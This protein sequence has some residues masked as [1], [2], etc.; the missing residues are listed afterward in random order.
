MI[1]PHR[2]AYS[3]CAC[4]VYKSQYDQPLINIAIDSDLIDQTYGTENQSSTALL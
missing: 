1:P 4:D 3:A 2:F